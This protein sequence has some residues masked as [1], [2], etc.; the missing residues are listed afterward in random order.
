MWEWTRIRSVNPEY[1]KLPERGVVY[2]MYG[3]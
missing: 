1:P 2:G 3:P